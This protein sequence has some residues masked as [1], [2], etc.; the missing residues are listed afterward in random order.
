MLQV[1]NGVSKVFAQAVYEPPGQEDVLQQTFTY[2]GRPGGRRPPVKFDQLDA[3]E[4]GKVPHGFHL[5]PDCF[6][7]VPALLTRVQPLQSGNRAAADAG[8]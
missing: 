4:D 8:E 7:F 3:N 6:E 2:I 5:L 1:G